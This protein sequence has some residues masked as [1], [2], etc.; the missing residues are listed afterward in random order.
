MWRVCGCVL[1]KIFINGEEKVTQFPPL[2]KKSFIVFKTVEIHP[3]KVNITIEVDGKLAAYDWTVPKT[4]S[5]PSVVSGLMTNENA[6]L[7]LHYGAQF[8][9]KGWKITVE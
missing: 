1:G 8:I 7:L 4:E 3:D 5:S 9:H 6:E 2:T